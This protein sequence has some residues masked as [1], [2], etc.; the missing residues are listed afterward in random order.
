MVL[1][2]I[3]SN[4][5]KPLLPYA[6]VFVPMLAP[7]MCA[8]ASSGLG[9]LSKL[10]KFGGCALLGGGLS[11]LAQLAQEGNEGDLNLLST[12]LGAVSGGLSQAPTGMCTDMKTPTANYKSAA[13]AVIRPEVSILDKV[14]NG[15]L[16]T[17]EKESSILKTGEAAPLSMEGLKD[18]A[19]PFALAT[20]EEMA[21]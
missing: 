17:L 8:G 1:D 15:G 18:A 19:I 6:A 4:E 9:S 13:D 5:I 2:I 20:G 3:V 11:S 14:K 16:D 12:G 21:A 7:S 10:V